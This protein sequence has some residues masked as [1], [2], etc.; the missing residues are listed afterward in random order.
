[1]QRVARSNNIIA[2]VAAKSG[3]VDFRVV[4][5][6]RKTMAHN[7]VGFKAKSNREAHLVYD[8]SKYCG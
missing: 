8:P 7:K 1:M 2:E 4:V 5:L 6:S 3:S